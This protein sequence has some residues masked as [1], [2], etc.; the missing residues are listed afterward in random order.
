MAMVPVVDSFGISMDSKMPFLV[1]ALD[2]GTVQ[3]Q[4][5]R[6]LIHPDRRRSQFRLI[7]IRVTRHKPGRRCLIEYDVE[8]DG[9]SHLVTLVGKARLKGVDQATYHLQKAL[10]NDGFG[11]DE[12]DAVQVPEPVGIIPCLHLW[13]QRKVPGQPASLLLA[14]AG[15]EELA[16][17]IARSINEIH[18]A[19]VPASRRHSISDELRI[20]RERLSIVEEMH[21][22]WSKRVKQI[23]SACE[24][25]SHLINDPQDSFIHRDFYPDHVLVDG[26]ILYLL[27]FDLYCAGDPGLDMGNFIGHLTEQAVRTSRNPKAFQAVEKS[28]EDSFIELA[29]EAGLPVSKIRTSVQVYTLLTLA[30]HIYLSTRFPERQAFTEDLIGLCEIRLG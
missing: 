4:F 10:W 29:G 19:K 11:R 7:A 27:D 28:L 30:R 20:L 15:A 8:Q 9:C 2:P 21:P 17:R 22:E 6:H 23:Y 25:Q 16:G 12:L 3:E 13:L 26:Q 18:Q 24:K 14:G 1:N 5:D